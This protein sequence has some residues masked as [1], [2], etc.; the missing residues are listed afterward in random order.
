MIEAEFEEVSN[1]IPGTPSDKRHT[2]LGVGMIAIQL[3]KYL[4]K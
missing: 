3:P 1:T 4:N 2:T